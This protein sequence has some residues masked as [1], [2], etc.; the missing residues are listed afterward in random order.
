MPNVKLPRVLL[1]EVFYE[2]PF[3]CH[4]HNCKWF[5]VGWSFIGSDCLELSRHFASLFRDNGKQSA[6]LLSNVLLVT[7]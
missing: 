2:F 6:Q 7:L 5:P 1:H 4:I 3:K